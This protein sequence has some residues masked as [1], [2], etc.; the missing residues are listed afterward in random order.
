MNSEEVLF[1]CLLVCSYDNKKISAIMH[2]VVEVYIY[3]YGLYIS[4]F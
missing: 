4:A 3:V 1:Q 2:N